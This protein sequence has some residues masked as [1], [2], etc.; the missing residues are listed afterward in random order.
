MPK[1]PLATDALDWT[2]PEFEP[3]YAELQARP[4]DA[5]NLSAWLADWSTLSAFIGEISARLSVIYDLD[6]ANA[7]S[8]KRWF[9]FLENA[10][11]QVQA[12]ENGLTTRLLATEEEPEGMHI[13]LRNMRAEV[14]LF[15]EAN[16]P[17]FTE[18][19]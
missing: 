12:A 3:H 11:P 13:P 15:R 14:A 4:L 6:T 9:G 1:L 5:G 17:L 19:S 10:A 16:L 18:E 8:E 2:W 7:E